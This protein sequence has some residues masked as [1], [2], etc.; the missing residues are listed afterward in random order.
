MENKKGAD[1]LPPHTSM[2]K[3]YKPGYVREA[4]KGSPA[5]HLS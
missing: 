2:Q 5:C 3:G 4:P 1:A